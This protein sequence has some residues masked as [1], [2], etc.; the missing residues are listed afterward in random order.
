MVEFAQKFPG[1]LDSAVNVQKVIRVTSVK[2]RTYA[3]PISKLVVPE[4]A[5]STTSALIRY[6]NLK[7]SKLQISFSASVTMEL[8]VLSA[9]NRIILSIPKIRKTVLCLILPYY[10]YLYRFLIQFITYKLH[11]QSVR[12]V[13]SSDWYLA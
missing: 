9:L 2:R 8:L 13:H 7:F 12:F 3:I 11:L 5:P 1:T 6:E 10:Q 4:I